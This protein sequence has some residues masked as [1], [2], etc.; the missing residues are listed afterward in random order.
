MQQRGGCF[1]Q[2]AFRREACTD[3][4]VDR[5]FQEQLHEEQH[6]QRL[7]EPL[8]VTQHRVAQKQKQ[9]GGQ[10]AQ[11]IQS[12]LP[13]RRQGDLIGLRNP[14]AVLISAQHDMGDARQAEDRQEVRIAVRG[15]QSEVLYAEQRQRKHRERIQDQEEKIRRHRSIRSDRSRCKHIDFGDSI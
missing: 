3:H 12:R 5:L 2:Q 15:Q 11:Q 6:Q 9:T 8:A 4:E 7:R 14:E 10:I 1:R 13:N